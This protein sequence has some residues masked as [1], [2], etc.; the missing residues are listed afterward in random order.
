MLMRYHWGLAVGHVYTRN[1]AIPRASQAQS[2]DVSV[3]IGE[4]ADT[5]E[6][7]REEPTNGDPLGSGWEDVEDAEYGLES[8]DRE[9]VLNSEEEEKGEEDGEEGASDSEEEE[10]ILLAMDEMYPP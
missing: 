2:L 10:R 1:Q 3:N 4:P 5:S 8:R 9:D 7:E 6:H